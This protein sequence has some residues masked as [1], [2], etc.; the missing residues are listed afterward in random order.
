MATQDAVEYVNGRV[1]TTTYT[2]DEGV[3]I[4]QVNTYTIGS[5]DYS[6]LPDKPANPAT[7][8]EWWD[9]AHYGQESS[10]N[11]NYFADAFFRLRGY[12]Q[13][14]PDRPAVLKPTTLARA[15][16]NKIALS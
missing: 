4:T 7:N 9:T 6:K 13:T 11:P 2:N 1:I 14:T 15:T 5:Y 12:G 3:E 8:P 16:F 10:L